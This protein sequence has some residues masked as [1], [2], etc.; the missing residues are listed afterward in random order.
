MLLPLH[1]L[2]ILRFTLPASPIL[3]F[4]LPRLNSH[5]VH[6]EADVGVC[7]ITCHKQTVPDLSHSHAS[8]LLSRHGTHLSCRSPVQFTPFPSTTKALPSTHLRNLSTSTHPTPNPDKNLPTTNNTHP[9]Q[10]TCRPHSPTRWPRTSSQKS[11]RNA[12]SAPT[13]TPPNPTP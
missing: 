4:T 5:F 9:P 8:N 3:D 13:S 6:V 11:R 1:V 10:P 2:S 7:T 12:L